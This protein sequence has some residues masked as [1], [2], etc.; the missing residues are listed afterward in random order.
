MCPEI[1]DICSVSFI[2]PPLANA[3]ALR[4]DAVHL[5]VCMSVCRVKRV[6]KNVVSQKLSNLQL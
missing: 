5:F 4:D 2:K 3:V 1:N 6:Y